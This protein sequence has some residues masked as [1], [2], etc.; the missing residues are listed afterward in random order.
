MS[1]LFEQSYAF[2]NLNITQF[3]FHTHP[4]SFAVHPTPDI[5]LPAVHW[6]TLLTDNPEL[7]DPFRSFLTTARRL[8]LPR[9]PISLDVL[10]LLSERGMSPKKAHEVSRMVTYVLRLIREND[11]PEHTLRIVDIGA[12]QGYLT[13]ALKSHLKQAHILA[14]DAD[15]QQ[16]RGAQKWEKRLLPTASPPISHA[17]ILISSQSL[18]DTIDQWF[19]SE[20]VPV[21]F[22][23]LHACGSLTPDIL[24]A[25]ISASHSS[26]SRTWYPVGLVVIGCCYNLMNPVGPSVLFSLHSYI[27]Y[28]NQT[29]H[30]PK[31]TLIIHTPSISL[32]LRITSQRRFPTNGLSPIPIHLPR[33]HPSL[34]RS[35]RWLGVPSWKRLSRMRLQAHTFLLHPLRKRGGVLINRPPFRLDGCA[36]LR[37]VRNMFFLQP[38]A[39]RTKNQ[40]LE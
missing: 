34:L 16:T 24:R 25:Y 33:I 1:S 2:L 28:F 17:T 32:H 5:P 3:F 39:Q 15:K 6:L 22:V 13:R 38:L 10:P 23:A 21:L 40:A 31:S 35:E 4:N 30:S 14:V 18:L 26:S 19:E 8:Q 9:S 36:F 7:P 12:G 11:I 27:K 37:P 29:S 20:P